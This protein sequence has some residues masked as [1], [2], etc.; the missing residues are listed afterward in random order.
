MTNIND[1]YPSNSQWL[2]SVDLQGTVQRATI[3]S[4]VMG[5]VF[6]KPQAILTF[7]GKDKKLGLNITNARTLGEAF[8]TEIEDWEGKIIE[9]FSM[10]VDYQGRMVDA[11]RIR[12][13]KQ[14]RTQQ[15]PVSPRPAAAPNA[16]DRAEYNPPA[17]PV[18]RGG[19]YAEELDDEIPFAPEWRG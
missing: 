4:A 19:S 10:K 15:A 16:R 5:S 13:P 2:K 18:E 6:D 11:I 3:E 9:L 7:A 14:Q 12:V 8:G 1:I 17:P